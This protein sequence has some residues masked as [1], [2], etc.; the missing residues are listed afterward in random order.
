MRTLRLRETRQCDPVPWL[1]IAKPG[2]T[3]W[4]SA[5]VHPPNSHDIPDWGLREEITQNARKVYK[6][7]KL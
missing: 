2:T 4:L 5:R 6:K 3:K 7:M 1:L